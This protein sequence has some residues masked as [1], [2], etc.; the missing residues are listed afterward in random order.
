MTVGPPDAG[1]AMH[2]DLAEVFVFST[3]HRF[4]LIHPQLSIR[5]RILS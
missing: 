3:G 5:L 1:C 2:S 4:L